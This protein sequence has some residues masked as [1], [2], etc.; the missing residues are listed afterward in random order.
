[1][2][3]LLGLVMKRAYF[4]QPPRPIKI[5]LMDV[6]KQSVAAGFGHFLNIGAAYLLFK[7][8]ESS[9][10]CAWYFINYAVDTTIGIPVAWFYLQLLQKV[11]W[12]FDWD[13]IANTGDYGSPPSLKIWVYQTLAWELEIGR[14]VQQECRDRSRMPSSA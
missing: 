2:M 10:Q 7:S 14:A 13:K 6:S 8:I 12:K 9:D 11:A 5:W 4:E 3:A 1:M